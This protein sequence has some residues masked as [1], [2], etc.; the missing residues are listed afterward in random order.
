MRQVHKTQCPSIYKGKFDEDENLLYLLAAAKKL[1]MDLLQNLRDLYDR[2]RVDLLRT[3]GPD[4]SY[5][6]FCIDFI[7]HCMMHLFQ[8]INSATMGASE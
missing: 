7:L 4:Q 1:D 5:V 6:P 3:H 2:A 8:Q